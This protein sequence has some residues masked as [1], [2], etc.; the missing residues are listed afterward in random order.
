MEVKIS[1]SSLFGRAIA[2]LTL[3]AVLVL[4]ACGGKDDRLHGGS[5]PAT[6]ADGTGTQ[7]VDIALS[8]FKITASQVN[9]VVSKPY[10]FVITNTSKTPHELVITPAGMGHMMDEEA[11]HTASLIHADANQL[12][13][14]APKTVTYTF[15]MPAVAGELE[16][17]CHIV[18]HYDA[19]MH[20][21]I[22]VTSE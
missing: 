1:R 9:F 22:T 6:S 19:G 8:D 13:T 3:L 21:P 20:M 10:R 2:G 12:P 17:A 14:G 4:A 5:T 16:F 18:G 11:M 15:A 7:Q